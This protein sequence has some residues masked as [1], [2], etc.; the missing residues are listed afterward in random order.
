MFRVRLRKGGEKNVKNHS[1]DR[2][3]TENELQDEFALVC[4]K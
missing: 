4:E 1:H 2:K 3:G